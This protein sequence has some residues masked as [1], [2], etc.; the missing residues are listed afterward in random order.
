MR[1]SEAGG[2]GEGE[3]GKL[4]MAMW[5]RSQ[6]PIL[7]GLMQETGMDGG[8]LVDLGRQLRELQAWLLFSH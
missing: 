2:G 6:D 5:V 1:L 3:H 8:L 7:K 4:E